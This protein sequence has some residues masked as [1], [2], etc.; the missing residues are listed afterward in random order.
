MVRFNEVRYLAMDRM[1]KPKSLFPPALELKV[2]DDLK[3]GA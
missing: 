3:A 2:I 1:M